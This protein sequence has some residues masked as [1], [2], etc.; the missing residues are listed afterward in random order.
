M[1]NDLA[2]ICN[3]CATPN[4]DSCVFKS[5]E[6]ELSN[7]YSVLSQA[8]TMSYMSSPGSTFNPRHASSPKSPAHHRVNTA[9]R[10]RTCSSVSSNSPEF[11]A[12]GNNWHSRIVNANGIRNK[13]SELEVV[14]EY[15]KPDVIMGCESKL[16]DKVHNAEFLPPGY[17]KEVYCKDRTDHGGGVFLAFKDGYVTSQ[18]ANIETNFEQVWAE[19]M[20]PK[21]APLH[22]C[23]FYRLPGSG[24]EPL[25]ELGK[26]VDSINKNGSKHMVIGGD[27]NCGHIDW[28][29]MMIRRGATEPDAHREL[30]DLLD[31]NCLTNTQHAPT[32]KDRV[33]DL[34]ITTTPSL[35]K[36]QAV[37]P[38]IT[39]V[40][41]AIPKD[42]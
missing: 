39:Y 29:N 6:L 4:Y 26:T 27:F 20:M 1:G 33:L 41:R 11:P 13:A 42:R 37:V 15:I 5:Y 34:H 30:L 35:I 31:E 21:Q 3:H 18:V 9:H 25:Q 14:V 17:Q 19:V 32:R 10:S 28:E 40:W 24:A 12:K 2:W 7:A 8:K 36:S 23:S 38:G 22:V 16:T